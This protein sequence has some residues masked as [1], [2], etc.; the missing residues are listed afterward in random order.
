MV[1]NREWSGSAVTDEVELRRQLAAHKIVVLGGATPEA[2]T[3]LSAVLAVTGAY[4]TPRVRIPHMT[5]D[6]DER[7]DVQW[8]E[9]A[10]Q[11]HLFTDDGSFLLRLSNPGSESRGWLRVRDEMGV[12]LPSRLNSATGRR[13]FIAVSLDGVHLCAVSVEDDEDWIVTHSFTRPG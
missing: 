9:L 7:V 13:E 11:M 1:N 10:A 3:P 12:R 5:P 2:P 6:R 8:H 4:V